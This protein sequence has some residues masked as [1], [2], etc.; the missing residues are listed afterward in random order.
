MRGWR[1][2]RPAVVV[3]AA[4]ERYISSMAVWSVGVGVVVIPPSAVV[5]V[6]IGERYPAGQGQ[7]AGAPAWAA[8]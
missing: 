3:G 7:G 5:R 6:H 2:V 1:G 8:A 4:S